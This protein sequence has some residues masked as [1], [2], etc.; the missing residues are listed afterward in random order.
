VFPRLENPYY[1]DFRCRFFN[2]DTGAVEGLTERTVLW[3][4]GSRDN[5]IPY[6]A[7]N[8]GAELEVYDSFISLTAYF[9]AFTAKSSFS[10]LS[11]SGK[12]LTGVF[13]SRTDASFMNQGPLPG[14]VVVDDQ[15]GMV[16]FVR[17][18]TTTTFIAEAQNNYKDTGGGV[19]TTMTAFSTTVGNLY[20][21]NSRLY[22]PSYYLRGDTTAASTTITNVARDDGFAL[23]FDAQI[24]VG[25]AFA[26]RGT[27]DR[28]LSDAN[29]FI[30]ARDQTV[31][32]IT[33]VFANALRTQ[34]RKRFDLFIR[35]PPANV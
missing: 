29:P 15:T 13:S 9:K 3:T 18:R 5:C 30:A 4:Q 34:T 21:R 20:Y 16:F 24:A 11:L 2:L 33:L 32:S 14:D 22:T 12:T 1:A 31:P 23:W 7:M 26:I 25:D 6:Y 10:S 35:L 8:I 28:W 27:Q 19:F 17:S